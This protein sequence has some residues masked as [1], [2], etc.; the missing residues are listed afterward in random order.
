MAWRRVSRYAV[1]RDE[2]KA[3]VSVCTPIAVTLQD[4]KP[5]AQ[6]PK[7]TR[8]RPQA[9]IQHVSIAHLGKGVL[10]EGPLNVAGHL[11]K[12][13]VHGLFLRRQRRVAVRAS[14]GS[15]GGGGGTGL[16]GLEAGWWILRAGCEVRNHGDGQLEPWSGEHLGVCFGY[17][18]RVHAIMKLCPYL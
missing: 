9:N 13:A 18:A 2:E 1:M 5:Q 4:Q 7:S 3:F 11:G 12:P 6:K 16:N 14:H 17:T 10:A 15:G 8:L